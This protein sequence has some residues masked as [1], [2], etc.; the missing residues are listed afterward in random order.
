MCRDG[1]CS[2]WEQKQMSFDGPTFDS[3]DGAPLINIQSEIRTRTPPRLF[4][5]NY[6]CC[7]IESE[8]GRIYVLILSFFLCFVHINARVYIS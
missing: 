2:M 3:N 6:Q 4:F 1:S 7:F 8:Y 5:G